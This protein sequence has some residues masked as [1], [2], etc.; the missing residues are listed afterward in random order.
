MQWIV[1]TY[2]WKENLTLDQE[3]EDIQ[4][5]RAVNERGTTIFLRAAIEK[6]NGML[7]DYSHGDVQFRFSAFNSEALDSPGYESVS[8]PDLLA[9]GPKCVVSIHNLSALKKLDVEQAKLVLQ[10]L[11]D[12]L[13]NA[14]RFFPK[15]IEA[16]PREVEIPQS[17]LKALGLV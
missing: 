3:L 8:R 2:D 11:T 10:E 7:F 15:A 6:M 16:F 12:L 17:T 13:L 9:L 5:D 14:Y 1:S 4:F